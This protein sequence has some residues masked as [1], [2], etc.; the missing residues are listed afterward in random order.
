M[1]R[2][3]ERHIAVF[4]VVAVSLAVRRDIHGLRPCPRI[5]KCGREPVCQLLTFFEQALKSDGLGDWSI[6]EKYRDLFARPQADL[7]S[8]RRIEFA[9]A[10]VAP[11]AAAQLAY[12][13]HL[14]GR[15]NREANS[16]IS[17][18]VQCFEIDRGFRQPHAFRLA[19]EARFEIANAPEHLRVLIVPVAQRKNRMIVALRDGASMPGKSLPAFFVGVENGLIGFRLFCCH[20]RKQRRTEI[21]TDL[22]VVVR[23]LL[24]IAVAIQNSRHPIWRVTF[25]RDALVPVVERICGVLQLDELEP[26]VLPGRLIK[27]S[28]NTDVAFHQTSLP[29]FSKGKLATKGTKKLC[30]LCLLWLIAHLF[31]IQQHSVRLK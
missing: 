1:K 14:M 29:V 30:L 8:H 27:M 3:G 26:G 16:E 4:V 18:D 24:D 19:A 28:V 7:I 15:E 17:K 23:D 11:G 13:F 20:P 31:L 21:E 22:R 2:V 12:A 9:S 25:G 6:V 10:R 5:G